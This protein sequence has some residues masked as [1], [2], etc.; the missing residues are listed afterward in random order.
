MSSVNCPVC[1][2]R[3]DMGPRENARNGRIFLMLVCPEDGAHFRAFINDRDYVG[4][5]VKGMQELE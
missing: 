3:L 5:V 4:K 1:S 2:H